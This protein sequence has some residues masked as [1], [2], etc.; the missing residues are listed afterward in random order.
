[1]IT[2][3]SV[4]QDNGFIEIGG[5]PFENAEGAVNGPVSLVHAL[6]VSS[7]VFFYELGLR[8]WNKN[9]L[10][11]WS[12]ELGIGRSTGLDIGGE[13]ETLVPSKKWRDQLA[14]EGGA[15]GRPWSAGDNVQLAT[16][17]GDLQTN[18]LQMAVAY[19]TL[20]TDGKVPTPHVG[21][22]VEDAAGRPIKEFNELDEARRKVKIDPAYR[23]A[24][25]EGLHEAAQVSG[26]TAASVFGEF[27]I[28]IAGKT[29]TAERPGHGNQS[30]FI[31]LSPYPSPDIV[32]VATIEE[33]GYGAESAA[34]AVEEILEALYSKQIEEAAEE[35]GE[36]GLSEETASEGSTG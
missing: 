36:E 8:M 35:G 29:G 20:G 17:Q 7:D 11:Q 13:G 5:E 10:Q 3:Q 27:P 24:I 4:I 6:Q 2:P 18:P 33:G 9:W 28:E 19:A 31:S 25:L 32:T 22:A 34:P 12:H 16:G 23:Q 1:M 21:K 30:W 26:G 14:A 15:E